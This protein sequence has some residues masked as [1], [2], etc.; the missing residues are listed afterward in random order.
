MTICISNNQNTCTCEKINIYEQSSIL[1]E[2]IVKLWCF[3]L[4]ALVIIF[5]ENKEEKLKFL[6]KR[7]V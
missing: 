7:Y 1:G 2:L 5:Q 3:C 4:F 6:G